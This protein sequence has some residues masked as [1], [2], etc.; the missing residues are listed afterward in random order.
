MSLE[1]RKMTPK[2]FKKIRTRAGL[3]QI[4]LGKA[5]KLSRRQIRRYEKGQTKINPALEFHMLSL[6]GGGKS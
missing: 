6:N 3:T 4:E 1:I 5:L 2:Q